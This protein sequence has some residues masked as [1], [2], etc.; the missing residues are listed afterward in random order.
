MLAWILPA[1]F[2]MVILLGLS[3]WL[4]VSASGLSV[5]SV[6]VRQRR[7]RSEETHPTL[8]QEMPLEVL[9]AR[10]V[11]CRLCVDYCPTRAFGLEGNGG[12]YLLFRPS[13]CV[14]CGLCVRLCPT[15]AISL[16]AS[17]AVVNT[18]PARARHIPVTWDPPPCGHSL[19]PEGVYQGAVLSPADTS[20]Q[21]CANRIET[22]IHATLE[23]TP[24][25]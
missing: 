6:A 19:P 23:G 3:L 18:A 2:L 16:P 5:L 24:L 1:L 20:C 22:L 25:P 7:N 14:A 10:C 4:F 13:D 15:R 21:E 11:L 12:T 17:P 9:G 8:W